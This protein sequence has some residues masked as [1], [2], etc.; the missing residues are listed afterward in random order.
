M[1]TAVWT[2]IIGAIVSISSAVIAYISGRRKTKAEASSIEGDVA[3]K[4]Y[5]LSKQILDDYKKRLE[6][7]EQ[8]QDE[9]REEISLLRRIIDKLIS[10]ACLKK[11]C[12]L[13]EYYDEETI[14]HILK[15]SSAKLP[16]LP[17]EEKQ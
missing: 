14:D 11:G 2:A 3:S 10:D 16:Q 12:A 15:I 7:M 5:E 8:K 13:R 17:Q 6:I 9:Q 4:Q 1:E